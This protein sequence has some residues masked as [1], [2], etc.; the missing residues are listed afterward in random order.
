MMED[1]LQLMEQG[2]GVVAGLGVEPWPGGVAPLLRVSPALLIP[3]GLSFS[4]SEP[5]LPGL[6]TGVRTKYKMAYAVCL[7]QTE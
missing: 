2:P 4:L 1:V 3:G 7:A 5:L 6:C